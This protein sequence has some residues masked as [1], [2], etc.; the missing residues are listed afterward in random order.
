MREEYGNQGKLAETIRKQTEVEGALN[1]L[2][3]EISDLEKS[4][5]AIVDQCEAGGILMNIPETVGKG[6]PGDCTSKASALGQQ[7]EEA[8]SRV[9]KITEAMRYFYRKLAV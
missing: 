9:A 8:R 7:V 3:T 5:A 6:S 1:E 4:W 2:S